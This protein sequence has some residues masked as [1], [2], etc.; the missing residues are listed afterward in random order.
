MKNLFLFFLLIILTSCSGDDSEEPV[1][2]NS[3]AYNCLNGNCIAST[4]GA[5]STLGECQM[6]C[7]N[8]NPN[9]GYKC[10][11]GSCISVTTGADYITLSACQNA[12]S[13]PT[14]HPKGRFTVIINRP[15]GD[16]A[17]SPTWNGGKAYEGDVYSCIYNQEG[18]L[19]Y[20]WNLLE[21]APISQSQ[22]QWT[23]SRDG[24]SKIVW[25]C[26]PSRS[27]W[28]SHCNQEGEAFIEYEGQHKTIV[29][30]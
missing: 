22:N 2:V 12:C 21:S 16:C 29:I 10:S 23:Y 20:Y 24:I 18:Q 3:S 25:E 6:L 9:A 1:I 15:V 27:S 17:S 11:N 28:P 4:D 19:E 5:Y 13:A 26:Y 30:W 8:N 14:S 7:G